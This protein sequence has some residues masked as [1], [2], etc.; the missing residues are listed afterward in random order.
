MYDD[1]VDRARLAGLR[2]LGRRELSTAQVRIR[3]AKRAFS[4]PAV[5]EAI[6]RLIADRAL[7]DKRT[8]LACARTEIR[9]HQ[10][11]RLRI[12]R[13]IE[14][15]GVASDVAQAAVAEVFG[16][17]DENDLLEEALARR[18]RRGLSLSDP[19]ARRRVHRFL[20]AQGFAPGR[21]SALLRRHVEPQPCPSPR[22]Q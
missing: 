6:A 7:D 20:L 21:V 19:A 2:M 8:A 11:G 15:L 22:A 13:R 9:L 1:E 17:L 18:L 4:E 14:S 16:D 12:L 10:R 3:L 5:E